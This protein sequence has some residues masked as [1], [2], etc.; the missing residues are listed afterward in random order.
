MGDVGD[1]FGAAAGCV[2]LER[3]LPQ[4]A[5]KT[6]SINARTNRLRAE[7]DLFIYFSPPGEGKL[8][9]RRAEVS[10]GLAAWVNL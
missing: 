10:S 1:V 6:A 9:D 4:P 2:L 7:V 8:L 5:T 3:T